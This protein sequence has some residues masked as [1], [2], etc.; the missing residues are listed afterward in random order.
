[1]DEKIK[2]GLIGLIIGGVLVWLTAVTI[3][4]SNNSTMMGMMGFRSFKQYPLQ[5]SD[6]IDAHFI[7]QMIPH[8]EDAITMAELALEKSQRPEI[9]QLA[10]N[11]IKSQKSEND[12]MKT[13]Y[14][15]WFG[16]EV[17]SGEDVMNQHGMRGGGMHMGMMGSTADIERL[18]DAQ[19]FDK[20]FIED[21][22]PHHQ[23]AVMMA[24]MLKSQT[25]RPEMQKLADDIIAAQTKEIDEMRKWYQDWGYGQ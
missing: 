15:Q 25:Q 23:M 5:N 11:I 18:Q 19:D 14:K 13:W 9:R 6:G 10:K 7:E 17:P 3:N 12:Q 20:V 21:M 24:Q 2:Y 1:M 8:H 4:N 22:I 16:R